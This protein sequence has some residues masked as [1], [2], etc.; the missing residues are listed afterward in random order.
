MT[1]PC[2]LLFFCLLLFLVPGLW[3]QDDGL[4]AAATCY[5]AGFFLTHD[6]LPRFRKSASTFCFQFA[7]G[8]QAR[9][10]HT[11]WLTAS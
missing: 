2:G 6:Y 3:R 11:A 8:R 1:L 7:M 4:Y 9:T 5:I 10:L